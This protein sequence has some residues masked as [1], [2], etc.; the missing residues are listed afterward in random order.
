MAMNAN[1]HDAIAA[2][3]V[4]AFQRQMRQDNEYSSLMHN[5]R[6]EDFRAEE[7]WRKSLMYRLTTTWPG[8]AGMTLFGAVIAAFS[9]GY[10]MGFRAGAGLP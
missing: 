6:M 2:E 8:T 1:D 7:V 4:T 3:Q 9:V 10:L 5:R